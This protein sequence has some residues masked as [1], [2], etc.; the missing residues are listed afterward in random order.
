MLFRS[1]GQVQRIPADSGHQC[2]TRCHISRIRW[3]PPESVGIHQNPADSGGIWRIMWGSVKY[4]KDHHFEIL[5]KAGWPGTSLPSPSTVSQDIKA[6]FKS[7]HEHINNILKVSFRICFMDCS[8][9]LCIGTLQVY[10]FCNQCMDIP[11]SLL[12]RCI[13]NTKERSWYFYLISLRCQR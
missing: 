8:F 9:N 12:E 4:C 3:N 5:M 11:I 13:Y 7:C 6:A 1:V 10:T 2:V